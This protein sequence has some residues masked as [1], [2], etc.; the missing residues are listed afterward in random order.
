MQGN[1]TMDLPLTIFHVIFR[2]DLLR[3]ELNSQISTM[4]NGVSG[5]FTL[6]YTKNKKTA[7]NSQSC[8]SRFSFQTSRHSYPKAIAEIFPANIDIKLRA[9]VKVLI[10]LY[11]PVLIA[12]LWVRTRVAASYNPS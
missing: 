11:A 7:G 10:F 4:P 3:Y 1:M 6:H 5:L 8:G 12:E 9:L 2:P